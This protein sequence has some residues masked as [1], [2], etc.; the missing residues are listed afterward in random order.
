M[1]RLSFWILVL[2]YRLSMAVEEEI[3][4]CVIKNPASKWVAKKR[5][6]F[7]DEFINSAFLKIDTSFDGISHAIWTVIKVLSL[8]HNTILS[9]RIAMLQRNIFLMRDLQSRLLCQ[10]PIKLFFISNLRSSMYPSHVPYFLFLDNIIIIAQIHFF[11]I[12]TFFRS[13]IKK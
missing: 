2:Y 8:S 5:M 10:C 4:F 9:I 6:T 12:K 11:T 7:L 1:M 13:C 3:F